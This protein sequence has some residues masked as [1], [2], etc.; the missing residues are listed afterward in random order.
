VTTSA[1]T[2]TYQRLSPRAFGLLYSPVSPGAESRVGLVISHPNSN[3][4]NHLGGAELAARGF[5][6]FCLNGRYVNTRR[7]NMLWEQVPLDVA[8]AVTY[9]RSLAN[10]QTVVLV[11][12]SGG[13]Q[14]MPFYQ[15]V[16]ENG[17][18]AFHRLGSFAQPDA[19][20][21]NLPAADGLVLLDPHHGY[22]ANTLTSLDPSVQDESRPTAI[23][24]TLDVFNPYN[25]YALPHPAYSPEF[26][27]RYFRAQADRMNR[28]TARALERLAEI[29][30][31]SGLYPDDEPFPVARTQARIWQLDTRMVSHTRNAYRLLRGDGTST[32]EV[33]CSLRVAG[34]TPGSGGAVAMSAAENATY[35]GGAVMFSVK[36]W[37]SSNAV[38]VN[39]AEYE[40]TEDEI[41]GIDWSSSATSTPANLAGT[42]VPLLILGMTG[43]YWMVPSEIFF[44]SAA[45]ADKE[46][47]FVEG[48]SH[49][50]VPCQACERYPGE[51]GDTVR[52]TF[53]YVAAWLRARYV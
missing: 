42:H 19:T 14:L 26:T 51:F 10:L 24:P 20:L 4:L 1:Y 29:Q 2:V 50:L 40:V 53:E 27:R 52:T 11:G 43:H 33:A 35:H 39:T 21:A 32:Q 30:R 47:A 8:P 37:L 13:G 5:R 31:G 49:N 12:H 34:V 3:Y 6:V 15:N 44:Q 25:G 41:R 48:A 7:E 36:S 23:D 18:E 16:A 22:G 17:L 28:L 9:L 45:A 46:L 38:R